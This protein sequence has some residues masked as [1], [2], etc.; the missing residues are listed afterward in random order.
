M[1]Q[2]HDRSLWPVATPYGGACATRARIEN[3]LLELLEIE[4][5][6]SCHAS[7][8]TMY[9]TS[10]EWMKTPV[11][12]RLYLDEAH[13]SYDILCRT[14]GTHKWYS[15]F[16]AIKQRR[17]AQQKHTMLGRFGREVKFTLG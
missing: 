16:D 5:S 9:V 2:Q 8:T 10:P 13:L 7:A 12:R 4:A 17:L 6:A 15:L 1:H 14:P 3:G 11:F